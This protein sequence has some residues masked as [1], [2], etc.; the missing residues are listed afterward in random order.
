MRL[1]PSA[2]SPGDT[3]RTSRRFF[4]CLKDFVHPGLPTRPLGSKPLQHIGVHPERN[5]SLGRKRLESLLHNAPHDVQRIGLRV[6]ATDPNVPVF[7][8][9]H[10]SPVS[11]RCSGSRFRAH[12]SSPFALR[13]RGCDRPL[14]CGRWRRH[15]LARAPG[16][17]IA[18]RRCI[19]D[20][21]MRQGKELPSTGRSARGVPPP[22]IYLA[23]PGGFPSWV[24]ASRGRLPRRHP[25]THVCS[26]ASAPRR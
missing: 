12:V 25:H 26:T 18:F 21:Y 14:R 11:L 1:N 10:P 3:S 16:S 8:R 20:T 2:R 7:Q 4:V 5:R 15:C 19:H 22:G 6:V 17:R 13:S 23:P 9:A 24:A